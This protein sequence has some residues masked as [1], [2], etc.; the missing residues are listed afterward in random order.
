MPSLTVPPSPFLS[1]LRMVY[2][3]SQCLCNMFFNR[4]KPILSEQEKGKSPSLSLTR[5]QCDLDCHLNLKVASFISLQ[6]YL[7]CISS[8][9]LGS[10]S[11]Q[12]DLSCI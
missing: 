10:K 1:T 2:F 11:V 12:L 7:N 9:S 6:S 5:E 4:I 8:L 3:L